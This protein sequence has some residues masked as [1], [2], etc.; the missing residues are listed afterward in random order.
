MVR[1]SMSRAGAQGTLDPAVHRL[2]ELGQE[3]YW[4]DRQRAR[5]RRLRWSQRT[6]RLQ[7]GANQ[8][9]DDFRLVAALAL[10]RGA[11]IPAL[12]GVVLVVLAELLGWALHTTGWSFLD[13]VD[14][15]LPSG[16]YEMLAA[17][18]VTAEAT[19]LALFYTTV[20]VVVS[21][22][23]MTVPAEIRQLFVDERGGTIYVRGV[24][25]ALVFGVL[26]L[27]ADVVGYRPFELSLLV[28]AVL[29]VVSVL[30]LAV[31]GPKLFNFFDPSSL[32]TPLARRFQRALRRAS[33]PSTAEDEASQDA[34]HA[35]A[36]EALQLYRKIASML[37]ERPVGDA[38]ARTNIAVQLRN[39]AAEYA[40]RKTAIPSAS[41]WWNRVQSH[42]NWLTLDHTRLGVAL[43]TAT[44]VQAELVPDTLWVEREIARA[45]TD[46]LKAVGANSQ[47]ARA[48]AVMDI[49][50]PL[51]G[52][53]ASRLQVDEAIVV[54]RALSSSMSLVAANA[55][56]AAGDSDVSMATLT[57]QA[58]A[59]RCVLPLTELWLGYA[60][61]AHTVAQ[62]DLSRIFDDALNTE[63]GLYK[64]GLPR[65]T[66]DLFER[67]ARQIKLEQQ[68]E[69]QRVTPA[70][71]VHHYAARSLGQ[72]LLTGHQVILREI[73]DRTDQPAADAITAEQYDLAATTIFA[74]LELVTK[75]EAHQPDIDAAFARLDQ[76]RNDNAGS[77]EWPQ[78]PTPGDAV[79]HL[80]RNLLKQLAI[81]IPK[82]RTSTHDANVPDLYGQ[83][84]RFLFDAVF[85]ALLADQ[86]EAT[87]DLI[88]TLFVESGAVRERL[89]TDLANH[90]VRAQ[91]VYSSEPFMGLMELSGYAILMQELNG[92][93]CWDAIRDM[94]D[95]V[96][97]SSTGPALQDMLIG[98]VLVL[99]SIFALTESGLGRTNRAM[100]LNQ[101]LRDQGIES[102]E[103]WTGFGQTQRLPAHSSPIVS[104]FAPGDLGMPG[105]LVDL[106]IAEYLRPR[107]PQDAEIPRS[108]DALIDRLDRYRAQ[109]PTDDAD[110]P[111]PG[112]ADD[113]PE[114]EGQQ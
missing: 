86:P 114:E 39:V 58:A 89:L 47:L 75:L 79:A 65:V 50:S 25:R 42:P 28:L 108:V 71:W 57:G 30:R 111:S 110:P 45:L 53:L 77:A 8:Q 113:S 4:Q 11:V 96:L 81:C 97:A 13:R 20:G 60:R 73:A 72:A 2:T 80:R 43:G 12:G 103:Y 69:G 100:R 102:Q 49:V 41:L 3:A 93:G 67:F 55:T 84:Y 14:A 104:A 88:G 109:S 33:T 90:E 112:D 83:A 21:N 74:S 1:R 37:V 85:E 78:P 107:L 7:A 92:H 35:A 99:E 16:S 44:G 15:R 64:T 24:V 18:A 9:R 87:L 98:T 105:D 5:L 26:I 38:T 63:G 51:P 52:L 46:V 23:Y 61:A 32:S 36:A 6:Q 59:Q 10:A 19:F 22:A 27:L 48:I 101:L 91:V 31:L 34:A 54:Q 66:L 76:L 68:A 94:W 40:T 29:A 95:R 17:A 56:S 70:W 62:Q 106:F 82:L